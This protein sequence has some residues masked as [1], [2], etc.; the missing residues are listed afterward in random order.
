VGI[1]LLREHLGALAVQSSRQRFT[2]NVTPHPCIVA[3]GPSAR[4]DSP[5]LAPNEMAGN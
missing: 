3:H 2:R 5:K 1:D 4:K